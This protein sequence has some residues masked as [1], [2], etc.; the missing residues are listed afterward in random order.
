MNLGLAEN[1]WI[2]KWGFIKPSLKILRKGNLKKNFWVPK[3]KN[4]YFV[5]WSYFYKLF[6]SWL[7]TKS[8]QMYNE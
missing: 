7:K 8:V 4:T 6:L 1:L 2:D 3:I 5:T